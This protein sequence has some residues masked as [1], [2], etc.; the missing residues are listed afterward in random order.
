M[1][2]N[3]LTDALIIPLLQARKSTDVSLINF[4]MD[5][6]FH[7][8]FSAHTTYELSNLPISLLHPPCQQI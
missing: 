2:R 8:V 7:D 5:M 3:L 1:H 6:Q 4:P